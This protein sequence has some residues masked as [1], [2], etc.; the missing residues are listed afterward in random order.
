MRIYACLRVWVRCAH[1]SA[2]NT[3]ETYAVL[4]LGVLVCVVFV[5]CTLK[6]KETKKE[7]PRIAS[8]QPCNVQRTT[9]WRFCIRFT[10][11]A[12]HKPTLRNFQRCVACISITF[13]I[14]RCCCCCYRH[15]QHLSGSTA[16]MVS[17]KC[18]CEFFHASFEVLNCRGATFRAFVLCFCQCC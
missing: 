10:L 13:D 7:G 16:L 8:G 3:W 1:K 15:L 11:Y 18:D 5:F 6:I 2:L 14:R 4:G 9:C 17:L 12:Q